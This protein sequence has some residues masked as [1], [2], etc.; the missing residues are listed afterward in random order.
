MPVYEYRCRVCGHSLDALQPMGAA[1]PPGPC[2][3]CGGELRR[4]YG[5]VAV[6]FGGWGFAKTDSLLPEDR[7][8]KRDYKALKS[9]ADEIADG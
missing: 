3:E 4:V 8:S 5:R 1:K 9:K 2:T 6:Q 7:R